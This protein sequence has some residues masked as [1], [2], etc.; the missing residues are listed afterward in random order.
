MSP[1]DWQ[2]KI[3]IDRGCLH[4]ISEN[5]HGNFLANILRVSAPDAR[6]MLYIRAFRDGIPF[7]DPEEQH[8]KEERIR[9]TFYPFFEI[10]RIENV[11]IDKH[12]GAVPEEALPG[13]VFRLIRKS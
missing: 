1:P 5:D 2:Y 11:Y 3:L 13:M 4:Q 10:E 9:D 12:W 6:M 8:M 7:G